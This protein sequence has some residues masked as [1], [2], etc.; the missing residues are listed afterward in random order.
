MELLLKTGASIDAVTEVGGL[1][2]RPS[3]RAAVC[4]EQAVLQGMMALL[5]LLVPRHL[6]YCGLELF[7][8][9]DL[10]SLA[11][12]PHSLLPT[13]QRDCRGGSSSLCSP[14]LTCQAAGA[15]LGTQSL[16]LCWSMP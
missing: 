8:A 16:P 15:R 11:A 13:G 4:A 14:Q 3:S 6:L 10:L 1:Q 12:P 9:Q 2:P 5:P 7:A